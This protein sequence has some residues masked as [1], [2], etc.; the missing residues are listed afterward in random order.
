MSQNAQNT[1]MPPIR[2]PVPEAVGRID[3][4][5]VAAAAAA[6]AIIVEQP[7]HAPQPLPEVMQNPQPE[8]RQNPPHNQNQNK[9]R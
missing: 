3:M 8:V 4:A 5:A 1:G 7:L 9:S 6:A 2:R